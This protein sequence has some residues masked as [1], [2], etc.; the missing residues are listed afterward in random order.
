MKRGYFAL[1]AVFAATASQAGPREDVMA[2]AVRCQVLTDDRAWMDCY[3]AAIRPMQAALS[4]PSQQQVARLPAPPPAAPARPARRP[5]F[6]G[7]LL[8]STPT[9]PPPAQ[10]RQQYAAPQVAAAT[11]DQFGRRAAPPP[12]IPETTGRVTARMANYTFTGKLF[13][14]TLDNGQVWRQIDGDTAMAPLK[15]RPSSYIVTIR[16]G[17][18]GSYNLTIQGDGGLYRVNRIR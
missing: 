5:G 1:L 7:R 16:Q 13:T 14:V 12:P 15:Q 3:L 6:F 18:F 8:G 4:A 9:P 17:I 2:N 11:P 10:P